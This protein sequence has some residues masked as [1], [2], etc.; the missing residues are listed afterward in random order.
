[1]SHCTHLFLFDKEYW[2]NHHQPMTSET[3]TLIYYRI[4]TSTITMPNDTKQA[5][6]VWFSLLLYCCMLLPLYGE[7]KKFIRCSL[8]AIPTFSKYL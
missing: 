6:L 5:Q 1:M 8:D 4:I 7:I 2:I 3:K